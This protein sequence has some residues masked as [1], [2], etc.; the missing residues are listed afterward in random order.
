MTMMTKMNTQRAPDGAD[1]DFGRICIK[2]SGD[3]ERGRSDNNQPAATNHQGS[4]E[5][6]TNHL[7]FQQIQKLST[8]QSL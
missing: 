6:I 7:N 4:T 3:G 8:Y 1:K 5:Q 2:N